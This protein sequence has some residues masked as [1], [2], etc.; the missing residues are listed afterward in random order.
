MVVSSLSILICTYNRADQLAETLRAIALLRVPRGCR[1]ELVVVDNNSDDATRAVV[2]RAACGMDFAVVY[3]FE[4]RQGKSYALNRGLARSTGDVLALTDDDVLPNPDWLERIVA[5]F[6]ARDVSFVFGKVLPRWETE[7]PAALV[8]ARGEEIWGPLALVDYGNEEVAYTPGNF[9]Q[10][11]FPIG[12]NLAF[13]R[14]ALESVGGW[15]PDLGK[16]NNSLIAGED[17]EIFF[18]LRGAGLYAGVYDPK[19]VVRHFVPASR[20]HRRYFRRW[21]YWNGRTIGRMLPE[22]YPEVDFAAA[23]LV[24]GA[25]RFLYRQCV[26]QC[27]R[28]MAAMWKGDRLR[29]AIERLLVYQHAGILVECWAQR[30]QAGDAEWRDTVSFERLTAADGED[31]P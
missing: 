3:E 23:P 19:N 27:G 31:S 22:A 10:I 16:V 11:R 21:F 15:R 2:E 14:A 12:A 1:V 17:L 4:P 26:R 30:R 7:P 29:R 18:R 28:W 6:R 9:G 25:P 5:A 24:L 13:T 8:T 20:L